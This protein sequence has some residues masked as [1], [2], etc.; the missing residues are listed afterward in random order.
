MSLKVVTTKS[1]MQVMKEKRAGK[2]QHVNK[3]VFD[4]VSQQAAHSRGNQSPGARHDNGRIVAEL[5][6][7]DSMS[8]RH[9]AT[10]KTRALH[11]FQQTRNRSIAIYLNGSCWCR[12]IL[13]CF[14]FSL[15]NHKG[16]Q[17]LKF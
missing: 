6:E 5:F 10:A 2:H 11:F 9:L 15:R 17:P 12:K 7:P 1:F 4:N 8:F 16:S 14:G 3:A 13:R